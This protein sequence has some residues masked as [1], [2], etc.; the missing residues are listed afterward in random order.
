MDDP[1]APSEPSVVSQPPFPPPPPFETPEAGV[2]VEPVPEQIPEEPFLVPPRPATDRP[3]PPV[4]SPSDNPPPPPPPPPPPSSPPKRKPM[5][6]VIIGLIAVFVIAG[7]VLGYFLFQKGGMDIGKK[8][9]TGEGIAGKLVCMPIDDDGNLTNNKYSYNRIKVINR[10]G[11]DVP[12]W[13]QDNFCQYTSQPSGGYQ[14]NQYHKR[15]N[16]TVGNN[17]SKIF[18]M[19]VPCNKTG[20]LD[21]ARDNAEGPACYNSVD[22]REW[23]GGMAFTVKSNGTAC[24][25]PTPTAT[26]TLTPTPTA[27]VAPSSTPTP[28]RTPTPTVTP[29]LSVTPGPSPTPTVTPIMA[30]CISVAVEIAAPGR[31]INNLQAGD[32]ISFT[33]S[34]SGYVEDI[35]VDLR[36]GG[37]S[38]KSFYAGGPKTNTWT[39][40][41]YTI[42]SAGS[43][44]VMAFI[45][46]NGVW[47]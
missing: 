42:G 15:W 43:Y 7:G 21:L 28:T 13:I 29:R 40:P 33:A 9:T 14:C 36:K 2:P 32:T 31:D 1:A 16:D 8:A 27:A 20:Q 25:I 37:V 34:F 4:I 45:K 46:T 6:S 38:V 12:V 41:S 26:L 44:E 47:K 39:T 17:S 22:N 18:T 35:A 11:K 19:T 24:P 30:A 23:Q 3:V 10:T 5:K